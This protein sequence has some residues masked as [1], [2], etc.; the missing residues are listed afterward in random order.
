MNERA[1]AQIS[2]RAF[3]QSALIL[4]F[5]MLAAGVL[6]LVLP[7]GEYQRIVI[8]GRQVIDAQS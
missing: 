5:M 3:I 4:A 1:G 2:R 7:A 6:T 8:E